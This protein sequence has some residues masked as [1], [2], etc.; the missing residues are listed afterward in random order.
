VIYL[1]DFRSSDTGGA[2]VP[3]L[4]VTAPG[5]GSE[6]QLRAETNVT[7]IVHGYNIN[8]RTGRESLLRASQQLSAGHPVSYVG[9]LWPGDHWSRAASYPFEGRDADDTAAALVKY[10][11]D[12]LTPGT[13]LSFASHSLGARV[14]LG[15]VKRLRAAYPVTQAVLLA[16]AIDDSSV[17]H[18]ADYLHAVAR[19]RRV[20]V[21]ASR[22]DRVLS[23]AY[24]AGDLL[25]AFI[26]FKTDRIGLALGFHGPRRSSTHAIPPQLYH[27]QIPDARGSDH[28]HYLPDEPATANQTSALNFAR[29]VLQGAL[30]PRYQ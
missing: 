30:Q 13:E 19:A 5:L 18:P 6:M 10:I 17:A 4:V 22:K 12:V 24:P 21:L 1:L 20:A 11:Q 3:G 2:V 23:L 28:G 15:A 9:V 8:R 14:V 29:Q 16:P 27:E 7:F 26:F 25:Q